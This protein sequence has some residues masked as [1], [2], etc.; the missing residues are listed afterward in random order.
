[1]QGLFD[2]GELCGLVEV[3]CRYR[4]EKIEWEV[5]VSVLDV[6]KLGKGI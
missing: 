4:G 1:M 2:E 6:R 3:K 5:E